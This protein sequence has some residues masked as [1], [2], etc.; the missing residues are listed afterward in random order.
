MET[1]KTI[2]ADLE[3]RKTM[4]LLIGF[5]MVFGYVFIAFEWSKYQQIDS[6]FISISDFISEDE[7]PNTFIKDDPLP[8]EPIQEEIPPVIEIV[9]NTVKTD[10]IE[11]SSETSTNEVVKTAIVPLDI[12]DTGEKPALIVS[13]V[14]P[15]FPGGEEKLYDFLKKNTVYPAALK[16]MGIQGRVVFQ[17]TVN[18]DGSI[19]DIVLLSQNNEQALVDEGIRVIKLMP[20]WIPG[21]QYKKK[22]RVKKILP[23]VFKN[24]N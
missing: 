16:E 5:V 15:T 20:K 19:V 2:T 21:E 8:P 22:V 4:F 24:A 18:T 6:S 10:G 11:F 14:P 23:M 1:K 17:F 7:I 12:V 3:T 9:E 13:E